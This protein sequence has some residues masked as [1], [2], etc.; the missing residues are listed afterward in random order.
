MSNLIKKVEALENLYLKMT[1]H[2]RDIET[3]IATEITKDG[4][5][6][7]YICPLCDEESSNN[8][9]KHKKYCLVQQIMDALREAEKY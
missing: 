3:Y 7:N 8:N 5:V 2:F 4:E 1:E 9:V 6:I